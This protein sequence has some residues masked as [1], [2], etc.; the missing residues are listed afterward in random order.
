MRAQALL[1]LFSELEE[2]QRSNGRA[3][4]RS[5][6]YWALRY[7]AGKVGGIVE[8]EVTEVDHRVAKVFL[9]DTGYI[10][11]WI[12]GRSVSPGEVVKLKITAVDA[13]NQ[14]LILFPA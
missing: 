12:P 14:H 1:E 5:R 7:Y 8:G 2:R 13:E 11:H 3:M 6:N 4:R 10:A 9:L